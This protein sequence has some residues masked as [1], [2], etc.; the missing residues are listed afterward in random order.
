MNFP[1]LPSNSDCLTLPTAYAIR[2]AKLPDLYGYLYIDR[3]CTK[4]FWSHR[5]ERYAVISTACEV[6]AIDS[7]PHRVLWRH[8]TSIEA[9]AQFVLRLQWQGRIKA[10]QD[11]ASAALGPRPCWKY[12]IFENGN[13]TPIYAVYDKNRMD[14]YHRGKSGDSLADILRKHWPHEEGH[15]ASE[16]RAADK[17]NSATRLE[18]S[19]YIQTLYRIDE[20]KFKNVVDIAL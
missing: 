8:P 9:R 1:P 20:E 4:P 11:A 7:K 3:E 14:A 16:K 17:A 13:G 2:D 19:A 5:K 12:S 10:I 15:T 6:V 18:I